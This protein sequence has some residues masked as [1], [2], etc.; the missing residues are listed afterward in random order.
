[1]SAHYWIDQG[2]YYSNRGTKQ[3]RI[4]SLVSTEPVRESYWTQL[5]SKQS[6]H[7]PSFRK[8][9][10]MG[11][12]LLSSLPLSGCPALG[13]TATISRGYVSLRTATTLP[14]P[15]SNRRR[16][17]SVTS[18]DGRTAARGRAVGPGNGSN[19]PSLS[20]KSI[21]SEMNLSKLSS[22]THSER[23]FGRRCC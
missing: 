5:T 19:R 3:T 13:R 23:S 22:S 2:K 6:A 12:T 15:P 4:K 14:V 7:N 1:M 8:Q 17:L 11:V 20:R 21:V 9:T 18:Q 10:P 16:E